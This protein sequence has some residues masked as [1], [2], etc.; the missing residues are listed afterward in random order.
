MRPGTRGC[1]V[2]PD[3]QLRQLAA[4]G[5]SDPEIADRLRVSA[6]TVLRHRHRLGIGS[7]WKPPLPPH[8]TARRYGNPHRCRCRACCE[9][10]TD[11]QRVWREQQ[12][13][14]TRQAVN[15]GEP[16]TDA[17]DAALRDA[18]PELTTAQLARDLG[19][20]YDATRKR[21]ER[22]RAEAAS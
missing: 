12:Q 15:Y 3:D 9:A 14:A 5:L 20:S 10:N 7:A 4:Q 21:R 17:E 16:W 2:T 19:R 22:L 13:R 18:P 11:A 8:G 6:R 1:T